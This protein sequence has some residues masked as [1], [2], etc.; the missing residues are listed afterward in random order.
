MESMLCAAN[1]NMMSFWSMIHLMV[2]PKE[3]AVRTFVSGMI[4]SVI[5]Y[6]KWS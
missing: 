5:E 1:V 2:R 3:S 4:T 6:S